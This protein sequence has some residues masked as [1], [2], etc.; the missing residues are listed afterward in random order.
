MHIKLLRFKIETANY[1]QNWTNSIG[2]SLVKWVHYSVVAV[3]LFS[4]I[5]KIIDPLPLI[6]T[7]EATKIFSYISWGNEINIFIATTLP[8]FEIGLAFLLFLKI[9]LK[10]VL[11]LTLLL[12]TSFLLYS[13]YG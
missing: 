5:A 2:N 12:F 7:L 3:L 4:G 8:I 11:Q 13:I 1:I 10:V 9:K 6:K